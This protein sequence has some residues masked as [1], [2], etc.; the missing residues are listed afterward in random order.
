MALL[1]FLNEF[2]VSTVKKNELNIFIVLINL[3][4]SFNIELLK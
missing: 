4:L 3:L 2:G 1:V